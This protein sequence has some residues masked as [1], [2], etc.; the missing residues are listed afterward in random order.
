M[1]DPVSAAYKNELIMNNLGNAKH[2]AHKYAAKLPH[3][4]REDLEGAAAM[5]LVEAGTR[6]DHDRKEDFWSYARKRVQGAVQDYLRKSSLL[7]GTRGHYDEMP[8]IYHDYEP[9]HEEDPE[10]TVQESELRSIIRSYLQFLTERER[11]IVEMMFYEGRS[12]S[13]IADALGIT[14]ARVSQLKSSG[15]RKLQDFTAD[16]Q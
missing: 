7:S 13:E 15:I 2:I 16:L 8:V 5:G 14:P 6:Y 3:I 12:A 4:D 11:T 1:K 9:W 10:Q